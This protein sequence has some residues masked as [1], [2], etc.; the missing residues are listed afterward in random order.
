MQ[1]MLDID[2]DENGYFSAVEMLDLID[3]VN[4]HDFL[5]LCKITQLKI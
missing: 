4:F 5:F 3:L 1:S 2:A